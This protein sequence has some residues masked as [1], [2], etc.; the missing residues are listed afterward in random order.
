MG[1]REMRVLLEWFSGYYSM[2]TLFF[3][4]RQAKKL[5][6]AKIYL[7]QR[8]LVPKQQSRLVNVA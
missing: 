7:H 5:I 4:R 6:R 8:G 2:T 3:A 1:I